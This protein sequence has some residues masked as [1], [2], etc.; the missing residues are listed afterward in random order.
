MPLLVKWGG[1]TLALGIA[2]I[3]PMLREKRMRDGATAPLLSR[4][5]TA[6]IATVLALSIAGGAI[7]GTMAQKAKRAEAIEKY[8]AWKGGF[9]ALKRLLRCHPFYKGDPYDPVP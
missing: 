5:A 8:G 2:N 7:F 9:L 4:K 3:V 1:I 6:L